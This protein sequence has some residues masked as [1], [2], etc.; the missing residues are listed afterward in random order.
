M[1]DEDKAVCQ[2]VQKG[3]RHTHLSGKLSDEEERVH[4]FQKKYLKYLDNEI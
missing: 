1:F 3:V 4:H 2:L